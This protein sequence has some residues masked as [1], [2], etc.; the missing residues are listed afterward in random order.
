MQIAN[1]LLKFCWSKDGYLAELKTEEEDN[2]ISPYLPR[3]LRYWIGLTYIAQEGLTVFI[4]YVELSSP[5]PGRYVW[6]ESGEPAD[7]TPFVAGEPDGNGVCVHKA[8]DPGYSGW[9]DHPCT[10]T[11][12]YHIA[13]HALCWVQ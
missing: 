3:G 10:Y 2:S 5:R 6:A 11:E 1:I 8:V 12:S 4:F 9:A 7:Y 13:L